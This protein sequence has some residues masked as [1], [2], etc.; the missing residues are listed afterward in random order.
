MSL[1]TTLV[2]LRRKFNKSQEMQLA[3]FKTDDDEKEKNET[4]EEEYEFPK[5][6]VNDHDLI[7]LAAKTYL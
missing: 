2:P 3:L 4:V 5:E 7:L 6:E 1:L